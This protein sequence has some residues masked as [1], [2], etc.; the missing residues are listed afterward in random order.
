LWQRIQGSL[1][2]GCGSRK[3][4][5]AHVVTVGGR[6]HSQGIK[7]R[8]G[9]SERA[10]YVIYG[11]RVSI[12]FLTRAMVHLKCDGLFSFS[13]VGFM[14]TRLRP[15]PPKLLR[16]LAAHSRFLMSGGREGVR[17][18]TVSN[19]IFDFRQL[20]LAG[21]DLS[22]GHFN[23]ADFTGANLQSAWLI[24]A[25][26]DSASFSG[27]DLRNARFDRADLTLTNF[28]GAKLGQT[29]F[30]AAITEDVIWREADIAIV[31]RKYDEVCPNYE[32]ELITADEM[33]LAHI[34]KLHEQ[35]LRE[36]FKV[37]RTEK[38]K[39][40]ALPQPCFV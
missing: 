22:L 11:W 9:V 33:S 12:I 38:A 21:F 10:K 27:C 1:E 39:Y 16:R 30:D 4:F 23:Y 15:P 5:L 7:A 8:R 2:S 35:W 19:E 25:D 18:N 24:G 17:W 26:L 32:R 29:T 6:L 13:Y 36:S 14:K 20:D 34:N 31:R 40:F 3:A 28:I 37:W